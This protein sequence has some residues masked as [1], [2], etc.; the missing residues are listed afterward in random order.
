LFLSSPLCHA[1]QPL[2]VT[3]PILEI[4]SFFGGAE[5]SV[6][7]GLPE[8]SQA[9]IEVMGKEVEEDM[10]RKG[11]H[12]DLWM[13]MGEIDIDGA[14]FLYL[15]MTSAPRPM[16]TGNR[17]WGYEALR[18]GVSLRGRFRKGE[19]SELFRE[20]IQLKEGHGLYGIFPGA[21]KI[22]PLDGTRSVA[23]ATFRL[24][25][26]VPEGIYRVCLTVIQEGQIT[27][28]R[29]TSFKVVMKGLPA[30]LT[31]LASR[32]TVLYGLL[33]ICVAVAG[34]FLSGFLFRRGSR[35][36]SRETDQC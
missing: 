18:K 14:P 16:A 30:F 34:G 10:M 12:W 23:R 36:K 15:L 5:V 3:P 19:R 33:S 27:E 32:H 24:P 21:V 22:S 31:F 35:G 29:C 4:D 13:N 26:R 17:P 7:A 8:G 25:A 9:V 28:R 20:F 2:T 6:S 1:A 11:R